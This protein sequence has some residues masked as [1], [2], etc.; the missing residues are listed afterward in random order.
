MT[1]TLFPRSKT[2]RSKTRKEIGHTRSSFVILA[3][4]DPFGHIEV[5]VGREAVALRMDDLA[6]QPFLR[7]TTQVF[8]FHSVEKSDFQTVVGRF[9]TI[10]ELAAQGIVVEIV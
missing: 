9:N 6:I 10:R 5:T 3:R 8:D 1:K 4:S 2:T 7:L